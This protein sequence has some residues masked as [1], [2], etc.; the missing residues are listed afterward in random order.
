MYEV[1]VETTFHAAHSICTPDGKPEPVH[2][3]LWRIA[4]HYCGSELDEHG[5]LVDFVEVQQQLN[6]I[7]ALLE[8]RLLNDAPFLN[9]QSPS[10]ENLARRLFDALNELDWQRAQLAGV[11]VHEAP[12]CTAS[13]RRQL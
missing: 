12:G 10:T 2:W 1:K 9:G 11:T 8:G 4:A 3:H 6:K 7:T 5:V 13:Y